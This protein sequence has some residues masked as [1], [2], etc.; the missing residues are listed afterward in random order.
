MEK[1]CKDTPKP[2]FNYLKYVKN[3]TFTEQPNYD[4]LKKMF[5]YFL[6][7]HKENIDNNFDWY[8]VVQNLDELDDDN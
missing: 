2:F 1:L 7:A 8:K 4:S 6:K 5:V 3:L